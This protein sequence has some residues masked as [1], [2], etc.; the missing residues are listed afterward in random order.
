MGCNS[1]LAEQKSATMPWFDLEPSTHDSLA[2]NIDIVSSC[3]LK[4]DLKFRLIFGKYA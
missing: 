1:F 2:T 3:M 4:E